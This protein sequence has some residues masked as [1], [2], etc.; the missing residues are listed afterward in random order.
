MLVDGI[1][2]KGLQ[3]LAQQVLI[4]A[5]TLA[6]AN[7]FE[8]RAWPSRPE[9]LP[10]LLL[11]TPGDRKVSMFPGQPVFTTTITL[12]V[13]GRVASLNEIDANQAL[14]TLAG[15]IEDAL[16][17]SPQIAAAVQQFSTI[18]TK[19]VVSADGKYFIGEIGMTLEIVVY[20][21]F[22]P[23]GDPLTNVTGTIH[24][25]GTIGI[26]NPIIIQSIAG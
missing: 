9:D 21:A 12:V 7:V 25:D 15:Q 26:G 22:G 20:Q 23:S 16:L 17:V 4:A 3:L 1:S 24:P 2:R 5:Q 18:E 14:D 19:T 13:V 8:P 10:M 6:G 11:Q